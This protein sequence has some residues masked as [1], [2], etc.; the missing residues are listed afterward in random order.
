MVYPVCPWMSA[1]YQSFHQLLQYHVSYLRVGPVQFEDT[2]AQMLICPV[3]Q[4]RKDPGF[5]KCSFGPQHPCCFFFPVIALIM[6]P[7][8]FFKKLP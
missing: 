3:T 6:H 1:I 4:L 2:V 5:G 8:P 7:I